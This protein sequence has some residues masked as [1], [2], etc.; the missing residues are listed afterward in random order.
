MGFGVSTW[1]LE[2]EPGVLVQLRTNM[3]G[4]LALPSRVLTAPDV[5]I[6]TYCLPGLAPWKECANIP[7]PLPTARPLYR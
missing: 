2:P 6:V 3:P 5:L 1:G 7:P 4:S